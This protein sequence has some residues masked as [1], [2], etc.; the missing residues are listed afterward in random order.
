MPSTEKP[1]NRFSKI[2]TGRWLGRSRRPAAG[3]AV[4]YAF[5][6][7]VGSL[8]G[9]AADV[10]PRVTAGRCAALGVAA[11]TVVDGTLVPASG[12]GDPFWRAPVISHPYSYAS[13]L[14]FGTATEAA[15]KFF[16]RFLGDVQVGVA[17]IKNHLTPPAI[18]TD[19]PAGWLANARA[20]LY[21]GC[22]GRAAHR[23]AAGSRQPGGAPG[24]D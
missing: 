12:L 17:V 14:V 5:G 7:L 23:G 21:V 9:L 8:Y 1:A 2:T 6:G 18:A 11:A 4:H 16:R 3:E 15:R 20:G 13:H 10:D 19:G 22:Y 24:M